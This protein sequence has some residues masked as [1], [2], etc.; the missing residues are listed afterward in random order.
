MSYSTN[1]GGLVFCRRQASPA[2]TLWVRLA[3]TRA[4]DGA[5]GP[6]LDIDLC[7]VAGSSTY[8]TVHDVSAGLRCVDGLTW[9]MYWHDGPSRTFVTPP[10]AVGCEARLNVDAASLQGTFRCEGLT[11]VGGQGERLDV[12][13]GSFRCTMTGP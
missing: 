7:N 11:L 12:L 1:G 9:D 4:G 8:V 5:G 6:H 10:Q 2:N 3:A 13:D